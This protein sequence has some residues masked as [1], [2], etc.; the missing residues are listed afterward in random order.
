MAAL[1]LSASG[2]PTGL[3]ATDNSD[4]TLTISST[5]TQS[6]TS[7]VTITATDANGQTTTRSF[8][9]T[10]DSPPTAGAGSVTEQTAPLN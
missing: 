3:T 8:T 9:I 2:L 1:T 5:P 7:S 10:V 6:G 4:G